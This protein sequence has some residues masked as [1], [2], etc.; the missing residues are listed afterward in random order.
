MLAPKV[1]AT[2]QAAARRWGAR[3]P[4]TRVAVRALGGPGVGAGV[5]RQAQGDG[6]L[7]VDARHPHAVAPAAH[8][9]AVG[10]KLYALSFE[11]LHGKSVLLHGVASSL[12]VHCGRHCGTTEASGAS[13]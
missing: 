6:L 13:P 9:D 8:L 3:A 4:A 11:L 5:R 2:P 12:R 1:T 7:L 10:Q